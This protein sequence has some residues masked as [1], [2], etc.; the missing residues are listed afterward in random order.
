MMNAVEEIKGEKGAKDHVPMLV[1]TARHRTDV[2]PA[3]S[4]RVHC[5]GRL[6][7]P[8]AAWLSLPCL[9]LAPRVFA[10]VQYDEAHTACRAMV[11]D[12]GSERVMA[13][14]A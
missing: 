10:D 13:A 14:G 5:L 1:P 3:G 11:T 2:S 6:A 7:L 12:A 9:Q 8:V 4:A